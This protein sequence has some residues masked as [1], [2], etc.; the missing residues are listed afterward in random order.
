M[1]S[2]TCSAGFFALQNTSLDTFAC[3]V[4]PV[5]ANCD[6]S[7]MVF[8]MLPLKEG[9][10]RAAATTMDV[11]RCSGFLI[12]SVCVGCSGAACAK[13]NNTYCKDGLGGPF[14]GLCIEAGAYY[15]SDQRECRLCNE[16]PMVALVV[17]GSVIL[18]LAILSTSLFVLK[19]RAAK[20]SQEGRKTLSQWRKKWVHRAKRMKKR[21]TVKMKILWRCSSHH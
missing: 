19:R 1:T 10:W 7:G 21:V 18:T 15:D 5:G 2:C 3:E 20:R 8:E 9:Y 4:C 11:R 12:D 16:D 17:G 13:V 14:C 6:E